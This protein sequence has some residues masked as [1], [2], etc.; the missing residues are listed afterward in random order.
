MGAIEVF[1]GGQSL[2][3]Q[4]VASEKTNAAPLETTGKGKSFTGGRTS[5]NE[6]N[7]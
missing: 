4:P 7:A 3:T 2:C 6:S 1:G 5:K